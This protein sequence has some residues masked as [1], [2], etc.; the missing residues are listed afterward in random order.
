MDLVLTGIGALVIE[1]RSVGMVYEASRE[2]QDL[3]SEI[4]AS[5]ADSDDVGTSGFDDHGIVHGDWEVPMDLAHTGQ[6]ILFQLVHLE[7]A[8]YQL[9]LTGGHSFDVSEPG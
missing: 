6:K 1:A 5:T 7:Q 2:I 4:A 3:G 9:E 8:E